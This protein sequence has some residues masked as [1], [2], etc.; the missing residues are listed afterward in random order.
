MKD[1]RRVLT[2][3]TPVN[4]QK[5]LRALKARQIPLRLVSIVPFVVQIFAAVGLVGYLSFLNGQRA[6]NEVAASLRQ[7]ITTRIQER[8]LLYLETPHLVNRLNANAIAVS[9]IDLGRSRSIEMH[10]WKQLQMFPSIAF[11]YLSTVKENY[12]SAERTADKRLV[13]SFRNA[14]T[15]GDL[16]QY[17]TNDRGD[18]TKLAS[19][20]S[21]FHPSTRPWY[22][23]AIAAGKATWS[24]IYANFTT[25]EPLITA[26]QPLYAE[27]GSLLGVLGSDFSLK[28]IDRFLDGLEIGKTG[29]TFIIERDGKLVSTSTANPIFESERASE[30]L[31]AS[32]ARNELVKKTSNYLLTYFGTLNRIQKSQ[33]L[34]FFIQGKRHFL[35]VMPL[36]DDKGLN[37]L[38]VVVIPE[39]DFMEHIQANTR[40]TIWLCLGALALATGLG[41]LTTRWITRPILQ[42]TLASEQIAEGN[43]DRAIPKTKL[44]EVSR[45]ARSFD[46]MTQQLQESIASLA[47]VNQEL[48]KRVEQ[49]TAELISAKEDAEQANRAKSTFL[50]NM[51][52]ELRTPLNAILGFS[53]LLNRDRAI[54]GESRKQ[55]DIINRSGE[56]LLSLINNILALSKIEAGRMTLEVKSFHLQEL[57][58]SLEEMF[59]LRT[60]AKGLQL[61]FEIEPEVPDLIKTDEGKL[62]QILINLLGNA[63][64]FS[65]TG[66]IVLRVS[67]GNSATELNFEVE[68]T[69]AGIAPNELDAIFEA[70][71]QT[72]TE[73]SQQ[74]TGLGLTISR[75]FAQMMG[76]DLKASSRVGEGSLF[77]FL[78]KI[79][80]ADAGEVQQRSQSKIVAIA[81]QQPLYRI[82]V[83]DDQWENRYLLVKLLSHI[84]FQVEEADNGEGA[85]ALWQSWQPHLILMDM[86]MPVMDGIQATQIIKRQP[87][88]QTTV[89]IALTASALKEQQQDFWRAGCDEIV[90]KPFREEALLS[91]IGRHL[92]V[93]YLYEEPSLTKASLAPQHPLSPQDLSV[94]SREWRAKLHCEAIACQEEEMLALVAQIPPS[95]ATLA[96]MLTELIA[97]FQYD[98]IAMLAAES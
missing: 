55:L 74:G 81:P 18:R 36:R 84:G 4:A 20:Y 95:Q 48:E 42:L 96:E 51:S 56:H 16:V 98:R 32:V 13:L 23:S 45:L 15:K 25:K 85:I 39:A 68:D 40:N 90:N 72:E 60:T 66:G 77:R 44:R 79:E 30:R 97:N 41:F 7:E 26:T 52:H 12:V 8:L 83:V 91:C 54:A 63:I 58:A 31:Y 49:R 89:I 29:E 61:A 53:Q 71:V 80:L 14:A 73:K 78:I 6:V 57:L 76:G 19:V 82:L 92:N 43:F 9:E 50:A 47:S 93:R 21:H 1:E 38:V 88:G 27:D 69:G 62:R 87:Q 33:Q 37:W 65:D 2:S 10:L 5:K 94:M 59:R 28:Q 22:K 86:R 3:N 75:Q 34:D 11:T 17:F 67:K 70:F 64:K 24:P 35:Q 46:R